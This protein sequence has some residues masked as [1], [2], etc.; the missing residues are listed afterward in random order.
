MITKAEEKKERDGNEPSKKLE[1]TARTQ[2]KS[3][4]QGQ[5]NNK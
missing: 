3:A 5:Q 4:E 1:E 2:L